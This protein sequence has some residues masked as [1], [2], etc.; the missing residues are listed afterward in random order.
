MAE[1]KVDKEARHKI[2]A[3]LSSRGLDMTEGSLDRIAFR[4]IL[5]E[6][7][8][9]KTERIVKQLQAYQSHMDR[10]KLARREKHEQSTTK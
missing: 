9:E 1:S 7:V 2:Y 4:N 3:W 10:C 5:R 6:T 8:D